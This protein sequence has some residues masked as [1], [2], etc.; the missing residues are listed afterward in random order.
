MNS[1]HFVFEENLSLAWAKAF[2]KTIDVGVKE[3]SPLVV[4]VS[5]IKDEEIP[6]S[7][8]IRKLLDKKLSNTQLWSTHATANTIFP[9]SL[10]SKKR[11]RSYLYERYL[12]IRDQLRK[13]RPNC[14]GLYFERLID[15]GLNNSSDSKGVNQL[16]EVIEIFRSGN[17]RRSVLQASVF[18][19]SKDLTKQRQRG[20]PCLQQVSFVPLENDEL[21]ISGYYPREL[22]FE[23]AYGNY[24]GLCR[25]GHFMAHEMG[26]RLTK[27]QCM[28]GAAKYADKKKR[29]LEDLEGKLKELVGEYR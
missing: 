5:G 27:M 2:L 26:L 29:D 12:K 19:P 7:E 25:L 24:L 6:E 21:M 1:N 3:I 17:H 28:I 13:I 10:W 22:I 11:E 14:Y 4:V 16:E 9:S 18:D 8:S 15:F 20:F 23:R